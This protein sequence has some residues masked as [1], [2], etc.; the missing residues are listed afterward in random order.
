M[1]LVLTIERA[2][3]CARLCAVWH[4]SVHDGAIGCQKAQVRGFVAARRPAQHGHA[5]RR[6]SGPSAHV[7]AA[8]AADRG[9]A[10]RQGRHVRQAAA[11]AARYREHAGPDVSLTKCE[12]GDVDNYSRDAATLA[13]RLEYFCRKLAW[14]EAARA[15]KSARGL[16]ARGAPDE[17]VRLMRASPGNITRARARA[18]G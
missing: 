12:G 6:S 11:F 9:R 13:R 2:R 5:L 17:L 1:L 4:R 10:A 15:C 3:T 14:L 16:L 7:A 8:R 18:R